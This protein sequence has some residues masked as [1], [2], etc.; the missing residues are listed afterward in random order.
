MRNA[1]VTI[2]LHSQTVTAHFM[3]R[4]IMADVDKII[5]AIDE[6]LVQKHQ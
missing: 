5:K 2:T 3:N 6:F 1:P 4:E